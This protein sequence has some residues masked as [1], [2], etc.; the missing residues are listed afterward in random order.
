MRIFII[1]FLTFAFNLSVY[2]EVDPSRSVVKIY[3]TKAVNDYVHPWQSNRFVNASG[4]GVIIKDQRILTAAHVVSDSHYIEIQKEG[5]PK[6]F[7]AYVEFFS[8]QADLALL[9]VEDESFF[10]GTNPLALRTQVQ[11]RD[12]LSVY[13]YPIG[14]DTISIT[15]GAVSRIEY[16]E[17]VYSEEYLLGIQI[18]AAIN[19]GNSGG[20]AVDKSGNIIGIAMQGYSN[21]N[22]IGYVVPAVLIQAF[23]D[24]IV[25]N[26]VNG[27][28]KTS[29]TTSHMFNA[30]MKQYYGLQHDH[31]VLVKKALPGVD[32]LKTGDV[33]LSVDGMPVANDGSI[34][35]ELGRINFLFAFHKKQIGQ[36]VTLKLLRNNKQIELIHPVSYLQP[37]VAREFNQLPRFFIYGGLVFTPMTKNYI[38]GLNIEGKSIYEILDTTIEGKDINEPVVWMKTIF[39]HNVNRGYE[40]R[41][42]IVEAVNGHQIK[43][44][45]HFIETIEGITEEFVVIDHLDK[46][47]VILNRTQAEAALLD[48]KQRFSLFSDRRI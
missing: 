29:I 28:H 46:T 31:G 21:A 16:V 26:E 34:K 35:T 27:F 41:W 33:I 30:S 45:A 13:G 20:P 36:T 3:A 32:L 9:K 19:P 22:N 44:F 43:N 11:H 12:T 15:N 5:I 42:N 18:D 23:L 14:G 38:S 17:Y 4:S 47:R 40:S 2:A 8:H 39:P 37:I 25:D 48:I 7:K 24:D 10:E 1:L 6:K